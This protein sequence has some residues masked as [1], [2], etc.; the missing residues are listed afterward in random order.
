MSRQDRKKRTDI[1][2]EYSG[3]T[4]L[5]DSA[6]KG[7]WYINDAEYDYICENAT[8]DELYIFSGGDG[9]MSDLR[10]GLVLVDNLLERMYNA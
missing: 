3:I 1:E 10:K 2:Y 5:L 4:D 8:E 9:S 6:T 7:A